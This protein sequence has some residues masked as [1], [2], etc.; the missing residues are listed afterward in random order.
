MKLQNNSIEP[1]V[2]HYV[3]TQGGRKS[4]TIETNGVVEIDDCQKI[5]NEHEIE[6]KWVSVLAEI[7]VV[8]VPVSKLEKATQDVE[9]YM[10]E[11]EEQ[12]EVKT[13]TKKSSKKK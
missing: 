10:S 9:E 11:T 1:K 7:E 6:N 8:E 12:T 5:I 4:V 2:I 3:S 13:E